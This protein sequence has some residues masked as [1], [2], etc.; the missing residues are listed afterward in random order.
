MKCRQLSTVNVCMAEVSEVL[1][2]PSLVDSLLRSNE[3]KC[4]ND[5][6]LLSSE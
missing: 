4:D 6:D 3:S 5:F 2:V 1:P